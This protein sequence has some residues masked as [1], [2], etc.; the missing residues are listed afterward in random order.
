MVQFR[1]A[2]YHSL[3]AFERRDASRYIP[4]TITNPGRT[5]GMNESRLMAAAREW[6]S[7]RYP[8][9]R[10]HLF[11]ALDWLDR[12]APGAPEAVRLA[13]LT[14]DMERA[15]PGPDQPVNTTFD[16]DYERAHAERSARLVGAWLRDQGA[17]EALVAEVERLIRA[18]EVGGWPDADLVQAADSL[19]LLDT[20]VDL[21]LGFVRAGTFSA[22]DVRRKFDR[23]RDRIRA[24]HLRTLA[25]PLAARALDRLAALEGEP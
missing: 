19:S 2:R 12:I 4:P 20:N 16:P 24:P 17:D 10:E 6:V 9:N 5:R 22:A 13:T 21:F 15:F 1:A 25:E 11:T 23:T 7:E 3:H 8:Y 14:H 18:H